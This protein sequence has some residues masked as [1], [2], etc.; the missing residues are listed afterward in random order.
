MGRLMIPRRQLNVT[1]IFCLQAVCKCKYN[2]VVQVLLFVQI[3][4]ETLYL[5]S[6]RYIQIICFDVRKLQTLS[7][8]KLNGEIKV[9]LS[10][11]GTYMI[12]VIIEM[13]VQMLLL[14]KFIV[15]LQFMGTD[16][17][18][19]LHVDIVYNICYQGSNTRPVCLH[20]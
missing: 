11:R 20:V 16:L 9:G 14:R 4:L 13:L 7:I 18:T 19:I 12:S 3:Q 10:E 2:G 5:S 8:H 17:R 15:S 1:M 6:N